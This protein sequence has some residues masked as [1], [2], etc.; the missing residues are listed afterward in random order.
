MSPTVT[1]I[2]EAVR[3]LS[4]VHVNHI[5]QQATFLNDGLHLLQCYNDSYG[6]RWYKDK[7]GEGGAFPPGGSIRDVA[8]EEALPSNPSVDFSMKVE[9][10]KLGELTSIVLPSELR[11]EEE[12]KEEE[13]GKQD[14]DDSEDSEDSEDHDG[15]GRLMRD[16]EQEF[17]EEREGGQEQE[18]EGEEEVS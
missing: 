4:C 10:H 12:E 5:G 13:E 15:L 6:I 8:E 7:E 18:E 3:G 1:H 2:V 14:D 17:E 16:I 11:L 9:Y